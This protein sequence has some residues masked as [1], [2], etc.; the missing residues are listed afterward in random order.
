MLVV[1]V[2]AIMAAVAAPSV[3]RLVQD[4]KSQK[5]A[6]SVLV[7]L[8]N[9]HTKAYGRGGAA[10]VTFDN[11]GPRESLVLQESLVDVNGDGIADVP[12]MPNPLCTGALSTNR[13][14]WQ[15]HDPERQ[16]TMTLNMQG[17][18]GLNNV[19]GQQ[20]FCFSPR[21]GTLVWVPAGNNW[22]PLTDPISF[23]FASS[24]GTSANNRTVNLFP[25]GSSRL[26]L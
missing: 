23:I 10:I 1:T 24:T 6:L 21:G 22:Q 3:I 7:L 15:S 11:G 20:V 16:T 19:V 2:I 12:N 9:A 13:T 8:Q 14:F 25:N 5:D 18:F 4:R 26:R 17:Q